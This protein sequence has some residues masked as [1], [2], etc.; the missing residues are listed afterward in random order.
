MWP[1]IEQQGRLGNDKNN[2]SKYGNVYISVIKEV[3]SSS[4]KR[5]SDVITKTVNPNIVF[6][7]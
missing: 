4:K 1:Q 7:L 3:A 2:L 6:H 5:Q